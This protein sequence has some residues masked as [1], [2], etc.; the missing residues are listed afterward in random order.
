[1]KM[2]KQS[3]GFSSVNAIRPPDRTSTNISGSNKRPTL[4]YLNTYQLDPYVRFHP[5]AVTKT[6]NEVLNEYFTDHKYN[7]QESPV[8][9]M[10]ISEI[11]LQAVKAMNFNRY[12]ILSVVTIAQKRAQSYNNAVT[13]LW[14]HERDN[15]V[16][17]FREENSVFIQVTIF[18][19]YLD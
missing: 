15:Y 11:L 14:D 10:R 2:R 9:A 5:P 19:V 16:D 3:L 7:P 4:M 13:F 12:R 17:L 6:A 8:L 18:G 1:M